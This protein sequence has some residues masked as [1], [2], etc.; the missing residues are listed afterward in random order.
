MWNEA[1]T[2]WSF[3]PGT[4]PYKPNEWEDEA[5]KEEE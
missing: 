5:K 3:L 2:V 1:T 4:Y